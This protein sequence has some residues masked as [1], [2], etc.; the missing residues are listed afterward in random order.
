MKQKLLLLIVGQSKG[1]DGRI[2]CV[3]TGE[4]ILSCEGNPG[5]EENYCGDKGKM[6]NLPIFTDMQTVQICTCLR[7]HLNVFGN[8]VFAYS[9]L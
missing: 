4:F 7:Y 8:F 3:G 6:T 1:R 2:H 9:F 5:S